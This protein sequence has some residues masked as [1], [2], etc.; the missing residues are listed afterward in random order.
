MNAKI[1]KIIGNVLIIF[2][3]IAIAPIAIPK[4]F[5]V[6]AFNVISGSM[7]P[8]ISVGSI[9][10]V[11]NVE[12]EELSQGDVIAFESGASV[13]THRIVEINTEDKLITTKGDANNTEDFNPVSYTNVIG[14]MIA[15]FPIYGT[16]VAWLTD[17]VGKLVAVV[18]LIIGAVLSYLG[19]DKKEKT[20]SGRTIN[21]KI[22]L[23]TGLLIVFSSLAG[24]IYIFMGYEKSNKLYAE[25][26]NENLEYKDTT[27]WKN[28]IDVDFSN[29]TKINSDVAGWIYV[30]GTDISYPIMYSG[31]DETYLRTTINK[32]HA[33]AG[34][35]FLEGYNLPDFSDSHSIVYGHNMRNLSM[36][37]S[38]KLYKENEDYYDS[39][40]YFQIITPKAKMRFE[41]FSYFD[42]EPAS[43]V[44]TVPYYDNQE[45]SDYIDE[46]IS[47]SYIK[48][49]NYD[50]DSSD[51]VV[52]LSTCSG[53]EM[54]FTIHGKL[55]DIEENYE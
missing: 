29:L 18:V 32:E 46:L 4:V 44:Y 23:A 22:I 5:G 41:I 37:G 35:I 16:I 53:S 19:E 13:V 8:T 31:D 49:D 3:I 50:I 12:F 48:L 25:L 45:F 9:V 7:E 21:P 11:R 2:V 24:L 15:H 36:F 54:R 47:H 39:H 14:R 55:V 20:E 17:T 30:E 27:D 1:L 10:Y 43:W 42:T 52:T 40:R 33:T 6:Q 38:L 51:K 34:S 26:N 28:M